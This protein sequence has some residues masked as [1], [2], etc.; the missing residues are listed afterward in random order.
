M[1]WPSFRQLVRAGLALL[2]T[3]VWLTVFAA[4]GFTL[5]GTPNAELSE[6]VVSYVAFLGIVGAVVSVIIKD[7]FNSE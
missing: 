3:I 5:A 6:R 2:L 4:I 1:E 7:L